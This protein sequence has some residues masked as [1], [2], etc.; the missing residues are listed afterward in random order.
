ML[1]RSDFEEHSAD[2]LWEI[3]RRGRF[4]HVSSKLAALFDQHRDAMAKGLVEVLALR[5]PGG[6]DGDGMRRL[7]QA[8]VADKPFRDIVITVQFEDST[9]WWSVTA[10]PLVD[11]HGGTTG[12]RGVISDVTQQHLAHERLTRRADF[13]SLTGLANRD[14]LR[15]RLYQVIELCTNT[16]RRCALLCLDLDNFKGINDSLGH[17][18]GDGVLKLVAQRLQSVMR[19]A[20]LVARLG[21]DEFAVL[22]DDVR[23]DEE[24]DML[25]RRLLQ[26]LNAPGEV[27]GRAVMVGASIGVALVPD[28]GQTIDEVMGNA[29]L[30]LYAAKEAGRGRCETYAAWLG[31]RSRRQVAIESELRKALVRGELSL[32]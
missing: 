14:K 27:Q 6:M 28:H 9:R 32:Q 13:D 15:E 20:D 26:V 29:D 19:R 16:P 18:V 2:V 11:D 22:L 3:D 8:L 21:G 4:T 7:R 1:F 24:V 12:W 5:S 23:S 17:S 31:E 30:A 25:A 10:K